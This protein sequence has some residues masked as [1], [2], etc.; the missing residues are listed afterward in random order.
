MAL[1]ERVK[2]LV[3]IC[4]AGT[5]EGEETGHRN[6]T[7]RMQDIQNKWHS[8]AKKNFFSPSWN[9]ATHPTRKHKGTRTMP[10]GV[11]EL[12]TLL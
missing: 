3:D 1:Q 9:E 10:S 11:L 12:G 5:L 2:T 7:L 6:K 4:L 8:K